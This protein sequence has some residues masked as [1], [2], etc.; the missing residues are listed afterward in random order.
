MKKKRNIYRLL[1]VLPLL[2]L[3]S[4]N[5][6][7]EAAEVPETEESETY[8]WEGFSYQKD[9]QEVT[10]CGYSGEG[11]SVVLPE[12]IE[13][14]PVTK[15]AEKAFLENETIRSLTVGGNIKTI[16]GNAFAR[17]G[18]AEVVFADGTEPL[19]VGNSA[20]YYCQGLQEIRFGNRNTILESYAFGHADALTK[21]VLPETVEARSAEYGGGVFNGCAALREVE[22]GT[23]MVGNWIFSNCTAL[24][25]VVLREGVQK[26]GKG[27]FS[28]CSRNRFG[29]DK[30]LIHSL[31]YIPLH[32]PPAAELLP[33]P[34]I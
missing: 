24:K 13:G 6:K 33:P 14:I 23:K 2:F 19:T 10:I 34:H 18:L 21:V 30:K 26:I 16:G 11:G 28:D 31:P 20:F 32:S 7:T 27:A 22:A 9:G 3:F 25:K 29:I 4:A 5:G 15:V 12:A 8:E 1:L 17:T